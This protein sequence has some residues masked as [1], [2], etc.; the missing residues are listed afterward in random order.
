MQYVGYA[1]PAAAYEAPQNSVYEGIAAPQPVVTPAAAVAVPVT[2][3]AAPAVPVSAPGSALES[4]RT[5]IDVLTF[6]DDRLPVA[7]DMRGPPRWQSDSGYFS[8]NNEHCSIC[9]SQFGVFKRK[10]HCRNCGAL[11][12]RIDCLLPLN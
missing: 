8:S 1:F 3:T 2:V 6:P 7:S 5:M 4:A 12:K 11:G 10:H 9:D